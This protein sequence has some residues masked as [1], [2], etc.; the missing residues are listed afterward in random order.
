MASNFQSRIVYAKDAR[1]V[2]V[3]SQVIGVDDEVPEGFSETAEYQTYV[4]QPGEAPPVDESRLTTWDG[5]VL[6]QTVDVI[7]GD[8]QEGPSQPGGEDVDVDKI[9]RESL[10]TVKRTDNEVKADDGSADHDAGETVDEVIEEQQEGPTDPRGESSDDE[11]GE[12]KASRSR[13]GRRNS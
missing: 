9:D 5:L 6:G 11:S 8:E 12:K 4:P 1:G 2:I 7:L 3:D 13:G 10:S